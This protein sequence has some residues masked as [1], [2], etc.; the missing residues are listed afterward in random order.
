[1]FGLNT[2]IRFS[3]AQSNPKSENTSAKKTTRQE[4]NDM[5][6][7]LDSDKTIDPKTSHDLKDRIKLA[8]AQV[9]AK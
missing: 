3:K 4:I 1:M 6:I 7:K 9:D 5:L 8:E 2:Q